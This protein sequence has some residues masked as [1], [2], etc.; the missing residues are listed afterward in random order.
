MIAI[1]ARLRALLGQFRRARGGAATLMFG[2]AIFAALALIGAAADYGSGLNERARLQTA[3]DA[4]A[5]QLATSIVRASATTSRA[6]SGQ[7][8]LSAEAQKYFQAVHQKSGLVSNPEVTAGRAASIVTVN[9]NARAKTYFGGLLGRTDIRIAVTSK[10]AFPGTPGFEFSIV[11]DSSK[12]AVQNG[13]LGP[14]RDAIVAF[15]DDMSATF[16]APGDVKAAFVPYA[17]TVR[18]H[19]YPPQVWAN[20]VNYSVDASWVAFPAT[21]APGLYTAYFSEPPSVYDDQEFRRYATTQPVQAFNNIR[22]VAGAQTG[23]FPWSYRCVGDRVAGYDTNLLPGQ[24]FPV[25]GCVPSQFVVVNDPIF[26]GQLSS[27][28]PM[29]RP[30]SDQATAFGVAR[31]Q[32]IRTDDP[33]WGGRNIP[34]ALVWSLATLQPSRGPFDPAANFF[35]GRGNAWETP[36]GYG[37]IEKIVI[38]TASGG[39][40]F[41]FRGDPV[42]VIDARTTD[43]CNEIKAPAKSITVFVLG[44]MTSPAEDAFL[45]QCASSADHFRS[46]QNINA[47]GG[48]FA[49]IKAKLLS[50][51]AVAAPIRFVQ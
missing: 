11:V 43:V 6:A 37:A 20:P 50:K 21:Q 7:G 36:A 22:I 2:V 34:L 31:R 51:A 47:L 26:S 42:S 40:T 46:V 4:T 10:V 5:M 23:P 27:W 3:A 19:Q 18:I 38:L 14:V 12:P 17:E 48:A 24:P 9:A 32:S 8:D 35:P 49:A 29:V 39:N 1:G 13:S 45:R 30:L 44:V 41:N 33:A 16:P 28:S 15:L 25:T